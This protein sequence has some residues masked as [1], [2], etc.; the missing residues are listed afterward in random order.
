MT[1]PLS[2]AERWRLG[3]TIQV[4]YDCGTRGVGCGA[5]SSKAKPAPM[6]CPHGAIARNAPEVDAV[7]DK[8]TLDDHYPPMKE[9]P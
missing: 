8:V 4:K 6:F 5:T 9:T 7:L 1:T 2:S 3:M